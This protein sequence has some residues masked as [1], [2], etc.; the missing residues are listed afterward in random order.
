MIKRL[1]SSIKTPIIITETAWDKL[2]SIIEKKWTRIYFHN[3]WWV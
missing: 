3:K 1:F 2:S